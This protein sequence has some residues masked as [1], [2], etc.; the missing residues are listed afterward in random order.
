[1]AEIPPL[2]FRQVH[3]DFHTSPLILDVA[4]DFDADAFGETIARA[5]VDSV[6]CFAKCHHGMCY[7]DT[8]VGPR[9]PSLAFDLL[10]AQIEA[11]HKRDIRA[12]IYLT[13]VWD[14]YMAEQHPDWRQRNQVG[15]FVGAKEGEP[16]WRWICLN[17]PYLDYQEAQTREL[18]AQYE[19]DGFFYDIVF[20]NDPG[21][22]CERCQASMRKLGLDPDSD[23]DQRTHSQQVIES[24]M[25][26][27]SGLI[28]SERPDATI[29]YNGRV[30]QGMGHE[31]QWMTHAEIEALPTGGWGYAYFPF[32]VR[33]ARHFDLPTMGMTGRFHR[34]WADFGGLKAP[35]ALKFECGGM[36]ANGSVCSIGDQLHPRGALDAAVYEVIGET[37]ADVEA[38]EPWCR[39]AEPQT[40]VALVLVERANHKTVRN[41]SDEGAVKMLLEL[42]HQFDVLDADADWSGYSALVMADRG[43]PNIVLTERL[44]RYLRDGGKLLLSHE[45][46]LDPD[47]RE[48]ALADEMGVQ[49]A[50]PAEYEPSFFRLRPNFRH[51]VRD[52]EWVLMGPGS[53]VRPGPTTDMLAD[54]Y[55]SYFNRTGEHFTSHSYSPRTDPAGYPAVTWYGNVVYIYGSVF[56]AYQSQ[57]DTVY[58]RLVG[59]AL[60]LLLPQRMVTTDAPATTEVTVTRQEDRSM[61]HLVSYHAG[62]RG[63]HVEVIEDVVPLREV[64]LSLRLPRAPSKAYTAPD[65]QPLAVDYFEG[66]ARVVIPEVREHAIVVFED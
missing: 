24:F 39:D 58:R 41:D 59:N 23:S 61:V 50:G 31:A 14:N 28:R 45:A 53:Y 51:G 57:G 44:R 11:L 63:A 30:R 2:R 6:T 62:R 10:G 4:R 64:K 9:H 20:Q 26:R 32:W 15:S 40:D 52:F 55:G 48:F 21:C 46:L 54:V 16:G 17:S 13:C 18:L 33:Y 36:L 19:C 66:A 35:A 60:D 7:F 22:W 47:A 25:S 8:K 27:L 38:K 65:R 3:L 43:R 1:M 37:Y 12:P 49:Y 29:F 5:H 34:S 56:Q 42:H